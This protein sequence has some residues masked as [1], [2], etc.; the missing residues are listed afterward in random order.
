ME[1]S[2][3]LIKPDA[4]SR[5]LVGAIL[6]EYEKIGL[7]IVAMKMETA[8]R[9][10][11][12]E[13]YGEHRG[14]VFFEPTVEFIISSPLVALIFE[15]E[16]AIE[17]IREINGATDPAKAKEGTIRKKYATAMNR[18]CVHASDSVQSAE[19]EI[20]IWFPK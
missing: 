19:R 3:V 11:A 12:E 18:N 17:K 6:T 8:T 1:Q 10:I 2:L 15:G 14:K 16:N 20:S 9:E 13:H 5:N 4:V 7:N